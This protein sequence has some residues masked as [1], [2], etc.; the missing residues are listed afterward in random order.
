[1]TH[2]RAASEASDANRS[3][4]RNPL[5]TFWSVETGRVLLDV[6]AGDAQQCSA[7]KL[8]I[9]LV[10][11][12]DI[13]KLA[14]LMSDGKRIA[15]VHID[16]PTSGHVVYDLDGVLVTGKRIPPSAAQPTFTLRFAAISVTGCGKR[17]LPAQPGIE[18][19]AG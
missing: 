12:S 4:A 8:Y 10:N 14:R 1:M 13:P 15:H 2:L 6:I 16:D 11:A 17:Q 19:H 5:A 7:T 3:P 18:T 9:G